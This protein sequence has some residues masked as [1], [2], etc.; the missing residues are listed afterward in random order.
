MQLIT[1]VQVAVYEWIDGEDAL[2]LQFVLTVPPRRRKTRLYYFRNYRPLS[3]PLQVKV[4]PSDRT[5][6]LF[7]DGIIPEFY[8]WLDVARILPHRKEL[9]KCLWRTQPNICPWLVN[10]ATGLHVEASFRDMENIRMPPSVT[11]VHVL[12]DTISRHLY[13]PTTPW[14]GVTSLDISPLRLLKR[15]EYLSMFAIRPESRPMFDRG[16]N[17]AYLPN[18]TRVCIDE[19]GIVIMDWAPQ[20]R[21]LIVG[22]GAVGIRMPLRPIPTLQKLGINR[23]AMTDFCRLQAPYLRELE[24]GDASSRLPPEDAV[25]ER[26]ERLVVLAGN[27]DLSAWF[28]CMP[29]VHTLVVVQ[30]TRFTIDFHYDPALVTRI[31]DKAF[32]PAQWPAT[33]RRVEF[34]FVGDEQSV[35][36]LDAWLTSF[37]S[38]PDIHIVQASLEN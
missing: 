2:N 11:S 19:C 1:D 24:L 20:L 4:Y 3:F 5:P 18:L 35:T 34:R 7:P 9:P 26:L 8:E 23:I 31:W 12:P 17:L 25:F 21:E 16:W 38:R 22:T 10:E 30:S 13:I 27:T 36:G 29:V 6:W 37:E 15:F 14:V 32:I 28:A 33:L